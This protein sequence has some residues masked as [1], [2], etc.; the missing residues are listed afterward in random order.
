M[1]MHADDDDDDDEEEVQMTLLQKVRLTMTGG[2][3]EVAPSDC[4]VLRSFTDVGLF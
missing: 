1:R 4:F 2:L 3:A